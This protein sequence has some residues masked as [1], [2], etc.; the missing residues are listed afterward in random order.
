MGKRVLITG[1]SGGIGRAVAIRFARDGARLALLGRKADALAETAR[2]AREAGASEVQEERADV[3]DGRELDRAL[4]TVM[5]RGPLDVAVLNAGVGRHRTFLEQDWAS[6]AQLIET[7]V[8]GTLRVAHPVARAMARRGEGAMV[9]MASIAGLLPV[10]GEAVYSASKHAIVGLSES[11]SVELAPHGVHVLT[12]CPGAVR[13]AF[14]A[15][16]ERDR[17]VPSAERTAIDPDDVAE[18]VVRGLKSG[19]HRVIVP[20]SLGVAVAARGVFPGPVRRG[21]RNATRLGWDRAL[22]EEDALP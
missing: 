11:L 1:A 2:L 19:A 9:F 5:E 12:V 3:R 4:S 14:V 6:V 8:L 10:P 13:T 17:V 16:D 21:I 18:A 15:A 20:R 7:N 22:P